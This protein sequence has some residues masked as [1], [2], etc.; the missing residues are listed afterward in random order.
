MMTVSEFLGRCW[1][2]TNLVIIKWRVFDTVK[3]ANIEQIK[4]KAIYVGTP[5]ELNNDI[6]KNIHNMSLDSYGIIDGHLIILVH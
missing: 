5:H 2:R 4:E 3:E 1:Y 6:H